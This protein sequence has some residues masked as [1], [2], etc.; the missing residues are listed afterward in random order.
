MNCPWSLGLCRTAA[1]LPSFPEFPTSYRLQNSSYG[2]ARL[3]TE[4]F[5]DNP[6]AMESIDLLY[7]NS[8]KALELNEPQV[9]ALI[10]WLQDGGH[11]VVGVE[12]ISD[13]TANRW[14]RDLMPCDLT[15]TR[16]LDN[17]P[18]LDQ[19]L[20]SSWINTRPQEPSLPNNPVRVLPNGRVVQTMPT[21]ATPMRGR[22]NPRGEPALSSPASLPDDRPV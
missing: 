2:A 13:I 18:Q 19:W 22:G 3:Q 17:H 8:T 10:A 9:H 7:L 5:P 12:Q 20:R 6:L 16:S 21:P 4:T 14:L 11:L 15:Q 1:G